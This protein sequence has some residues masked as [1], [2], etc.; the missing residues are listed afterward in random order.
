MLQL[1]RLDISLEQ[2]KRF[3]QNRKTIDLNLTN[4]TLD[5]T[6][7][8]DID[9]DSPEE[10]VSLATRDYSNTIRLIDDQYVSYHFSNNYSCITLYVL[11]GTQTIKINLPSSSMNKQ[12]T[13]TISGNSNGTIIK[14][15]L[16]LKDGS[17]IS[18]RLPS[19]L[20]TTDNTEL[21]INNYDDLYKILYPYDFSVRIPHY[22]YSIRNN[23]Y[24]VVMEDGGLLC[25]H[26]DNDFTTCKTTIFTDSSYF[27]SL[28][29]F[30]RKKQN[31]TKLNRAVSCQLYKDDVLIILTQNCKLR[32]WNLR[33]YQLINEIDLS[34]DMEIDGLSL[35]NFVDP[36]NFLTIKD[37]V[38]IIFLP[39]NNGIFKIGKI[40][41]SSNSNI[42][43][44]CS[45]IIPS[46]LSSSSIWSFSDIEILNFNSVSS[47]PLN[48]LNALN[49]CILWKSG[50]LSKVQIL[51]LDL[52]TIQS[53]MK[54]KWF[55]SLDKSLND[56]E[57]EFMVTDSNQISF[58][59]V[60][61]KLR[62]YYSYST[63]QEAEELLIENNITPNNNQQIYLQNLITL[64]RDLKNSNSDSFSLTVY[65][66][67]II[68][69]NNTQMYD[70]TALQMN[71]QLENMFYENGSGSTLSK[72][73]DVLG[74]ITNSLSYSAFQSISDEFIKIAIKFN[75]ST[76]SNQEEFLKEFSNVCKQDH[77]I[78]QFDI[79]NIDN[80]I[81]QLND[82]DVI[83]L[84]DEMLNNYLLSTNFDES[85]YFPA[86]NEDAFNASI[87]V[88]SLQNH[89]LIQRKI[90]LQNLITFTLLNF[91]DEV[92]LSKIKKL[93]DIN[94]KQNLLLG[95]YD[96][97]KELLIKEVFKLTSKYASGIKL[98]SCK[99]LISYV[100]HI[101]ASF[102]GEPE[103][104]QNP[105]KNKF[106]EETILFHNENNISQHDSQKFLQNVLRPYFH[107][108]DVIE[109]LLLGM[110][111]FV[112]GDYDNSFKLLT[113][114]NYT[115]DLVNTLPLSLKNLADSNLVG[116]I[117]ISL[118]RSFNKL[119]LNESW[120]LFEL[121][122][123]FTTND[124]YDFALHCIKTS[125]EKVMSNPNIE[126]IEESQSEIEFRTI[127]LTQ[128]IEILNHFDMIEEIIDVLRLSHKYL[129][130][131]KRREYFTMLLTNGNKSEKSLSTLLRLCRDD[132][133]IFLNV[134]DFN[135]VDEILLKQIDGINDWRGY[136]RVYSM[137]YVNSRLR[138]A[139]EIILEYVK[140]NNDDEI[141]KKAGLLIVCNILS[142]FTEPQ[143]RWVLYQSQILNL[144][145]IRKEIVF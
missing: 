48:F 109:E 49:L 121:S 100:E 64:L 98:N 86:I 68:L 126:L 30:L 89:V 36:G 32:F 132:K 123:L 81:N 83:N 19:K 131:I 41:Y 136:K 40:S 113:K 7:D 15:K 91:N 141:H 23:E 37:D 42:S 1:S 99:G 84:L 117:W 77:I 101:L 14:M 67:D 25:L 70:Y 102:F 129:S 39:F 140:N 54:F 18:I 24:I 22:L 114:N 133:G 12:F 79:D 112:C 116:N 2:F 76:T 139:A 145:D 62:S 118:S 26:W 57:L 124:Q 115:K 107:S 63:L 105:I 33:N 50:Y 144:E 56:A 28:T 78:S 134:D 122:K 125:I 106:F 87:I 103:I 47:S 8:M 17:F 128:Y 73:L 88:E 96:F 65:N 44:T 38:L 16:I 61:D 27:K 138:S 90:V 119:F 135:M 120:Y 104:L 51:S 127:Q 4:D 72:Y 94:L 108:N 74:D 43:F 55:E 66:D 58:S 97:D 137:R 46:N 69:L 143:D 85:E 21:D 142:S 92:L 5:A 31:D 34:A 82:F 45:S 71:S 20:L 9:A 53:N 75:S 35:R 29:N 10:A 3:N 95:L 80:I 52:S 13:F 93:L 111:Y 6:V 130:P 11:N 60:I 110:T 59:T